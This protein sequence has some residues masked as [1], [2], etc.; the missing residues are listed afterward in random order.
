MYNWFAKQNMEKRENKEE[1]WEGREWREGRGEGKKEGNY[2]G[3]KQYRP[4]NMYK[5]HFNNNP[6][7]LR[8]VSAESQV[9]QTILYP[10]LLKLDAF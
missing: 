10:L 3:K 9:Q 6:C 7:S 2:R 4:H 1:E 8:Q 5:W